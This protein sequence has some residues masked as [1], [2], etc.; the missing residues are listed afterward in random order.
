MNL[1]LLLA[2]TVELIKLFSNID[3]YLKIFSFPSFH[4][5]MSSKIWFQQEKLHH[6]KN[7]WQRFS[8]TERNP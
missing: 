1:S 4:L 6:A 3:R 8:S 2:E 5:K 7:K